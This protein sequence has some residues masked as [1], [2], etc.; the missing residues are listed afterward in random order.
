MYASQSAPSEIMCVFR[1][2]TE[3]SSRIMILFFCAR[4]CMNEI[5]MCVVPLAEELEA[6]GLKSSAQTNAPGNTR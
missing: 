3:A 6:R 1:D 2:R 4:S 5:Q